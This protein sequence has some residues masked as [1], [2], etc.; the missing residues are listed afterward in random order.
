MSSS[1]YG[2]GQSKAE[3]KPGTMDFEEVKLENLPPYTPRQYEGDGPVPYPEVALRAVTPRKR[4]HRKWAII[5]ILMILGAMLTVA[6]VAGVWNNAMNAKKA[7]ENGG[8]TGLPKVVATTTIM[9]VSVDTVTAMPSIPATYNSEITGTQ[10]TV[11]PISVPTIIVPSISVPESIHIPTP[12]ASSSTATPSV[13]TPAVLLPDP[14]VG[15][16]TSVAT[17][18]VETPA[19]P[20]PSNHHY[21]VTP[22]AAATTPFNNP[23][24]NDDKM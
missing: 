11:T 2:K 8:P 24:G 19:D 15:P 23:Y 10:T 6:I 7:D 1:F 21:Q 16:S 9:S 14:S 17:R 13:V 22:A 12:P 5:I 18:S 20:F 4:P 3:P